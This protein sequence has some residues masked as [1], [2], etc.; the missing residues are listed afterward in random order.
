MWWVQNNSIPM[1]HSIAPKRNLNMAAL[2]NVLDWQMSTE[3]Q[4][5]TDNQSLKGDNV[6]Q[7]VEAR[8]D[9]AWR[10]PWSVRDFVVGNHHSIARW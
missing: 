2:T 6:C 7:H 3:A 10:P 1:E 9:N 8:R 5:P 4:R